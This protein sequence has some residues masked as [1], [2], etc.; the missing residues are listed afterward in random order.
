LAAADLE[1]DVIVK[2]GNR[3]VADAYEYVVAVRLL[4]IG[5]PATVEAVRDGRPVTLTVTPDANG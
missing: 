5:Q 3:S 1:N 4:K 2:V